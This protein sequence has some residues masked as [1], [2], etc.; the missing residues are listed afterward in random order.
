[1]QLKNRLK[2]YDDRLLIKIEHKDKVRIKNI[3]FKNKKT[4][5]DLL[6]MLIKIYI[7]LYDTKKLNNKVI[8]D[9]DELYKT[10][11][12]IGGILNK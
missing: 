11:K 2:L 4:M 3:A 5:S 12:M 10:I 9:D 7:K 1:M 8:K 6:R